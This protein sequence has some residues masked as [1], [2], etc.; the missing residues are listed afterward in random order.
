M[1]TIIRAITSSIIDQS[2]ARPFFKYNEQAQPE[3]VATWH[4]EWGPGIHTILMIDRLVDDQQFSDKAAPQLL[5]G[6]LPNG[7]VNGAANVPFD[8]NYREKF[9]V[10][11]AELNQILQWDRVLVVA[12]GR[13]QSGEFHTQDQFSN[14]GSY[15][16][17][18]SASP[19]SG[20]TTGLF[21]R[22]TG[23]GYLTV[24]PLNHLWL[25]GGVAADDEKFPDSF[26]N[27]PVLPGEQSRS[28]IGPKAA[29]VWSPDPM[30]TL[31]GIFTHSL[32]GAS[33]DESVRLEPTELAGFPQAFRS[34]ISE[35]AV[36]SQSAPTFDTL[37]GAID[38]KLGARTYAG[39]QF[40]RLA[41]EANQGQGVFELADG[42]TPAIIGLTP[43]QLS[44]VEHAGSVSLNQLLGD[45]FVLGGACKITQS[46]L[47][48]S[49]PDVSEDVIS[50]SHFVSTLQEVDTYVL[51]NHSSGF[52]AKLEAN[53]YGQGNFG[54]NPAEPYSSFFQEN[55]YTGYRFA[56][57][58]AELQ[59]GVLNLSGG[60]YNLDPL[61]VYQ[62]LPRKRVFEASFNFL[63]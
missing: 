14:P 17:Y 57:R 11:G 25:T 45:G 27:P 50:A 5:L 32:G 60:G 24:K 63:F 28:Q 4:H 20:D 19:Y 3:L 15:Q 9:E 47:H 21:Q 2:D 10:Y 36:G 42:G 55:I 18:F 61:T 62:E 41:S 40:E 13:Y 38:L 12:G 53:W 44:Y 59:L 34:L 39:I 43:E 35:S 56:H 48:G 49:F 7:A 1:K 52:Y 8:F 54:A 23:Y 46:D 30:V 31:R 37:G 29:I 6:E 16:S 26:R 58:R 51:F 33:I 22:V